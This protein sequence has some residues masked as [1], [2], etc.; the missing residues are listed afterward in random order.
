MNAYARRHQ[1]APREPWSLWGRPTAPA[2]VT[3]RDQVAAVLR[4]ARQHRLAGNLHRARALLVGTV[5]G[6]PR[7]LVALYSPDFTP[8]PR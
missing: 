7:G 5:P 2:P 1:H 3:P 6:R 8:L 4:I